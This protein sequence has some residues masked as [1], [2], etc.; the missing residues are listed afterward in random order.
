MRGSAGLRVATNVPVPVPTHWHA[1]GSSHAEDA[2]PLYRDLPGLVHIASLPNYRQE[3]TVATGGGVLAGTTL[4]G[5]LIHRLLAVAMP[6]INAT[7]CLLRSHVQSACPGGP[8]W[9]FCATLPTTP[10]WRRSLHGA[11]ASAWQVL[12]GLHMGVRVAGEIDTGV[13]CVSI[14][15]RRGSVWRLLGP[16]GSSE[17]VLQTHLHWHTLALQALDAATGML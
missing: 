14:T 3:G 6:R 15:D 7:P 1:G 5:P 2:A 9:T 17:T 13:G 4:V 8:C 16:E 11:C 10:A 12:H